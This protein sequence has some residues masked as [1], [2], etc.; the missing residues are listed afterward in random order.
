M[1][2]CIF[3]WYEYIIHRITSG[4]G[5]SLKTTDCTIEI[6]I[7]HPIKISSAGDTKKTLIKFE[8]ISIVFSI[9][10]EGTRYMIRISS[11]SSYEKHMKS[12]IEVHNRID[13]NLWS[14]LVHNLT[15]WIC[16][17]INNLDVYRFGS[18]VWIPQL[19]LA[20]LY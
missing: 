9:A 16:I 4:I 17:I 11:C 14:R 5:I 13:P 10:Q 1:Y 15:R 18:A 20:P 2:P 3:V 19:D 6:N 8:N 12:R 7:N